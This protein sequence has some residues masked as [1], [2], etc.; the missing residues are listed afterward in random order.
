VVVVVVVVGVVVVFVVPSV[1]GCDVNAYVSA[2]A[3][4]TMLIIAKD[5]IFCFVLI[6]L[7][8]GVSVIRITDKKKETFGLL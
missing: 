6:F 4:A 1:G 8:G 3:L 7:S 5:A 2:A